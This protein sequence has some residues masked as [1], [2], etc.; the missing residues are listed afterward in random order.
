MNQVTHWNPFKS[1]SRIGAGSSSEFDDLLRSA[2]LRPLLGQFD[3]PDIRVDV[4]ESDKSYTVKADLPGVK[5][6]DIDISVDGRQV[7][8]SASTSKRTEK[9]DKT[10]LYTERSEGRIYRSF[11]LPAEVD[12]K[13]AQARYANGVLDL[14]LPKKGN[15]NGQRIP[16]A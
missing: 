5:K 15:G 3:V 7:T 14:E 4:E 11:A 12:G 16:V 8:I 6:E 10:S 1:L 2:G 13:K 9:K